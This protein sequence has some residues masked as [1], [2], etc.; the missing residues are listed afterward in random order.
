MSNQPGP[1]RR[2][3]SHQTGFTLVEIMIVVA[4]I[5][6]LAAIAVPAYNDYIVRSRITHATSGLADR[7]TRMEQFF[8]DNHVFFQAAAGS[9]PELNSP[10]CV[11]DATASPFFTFTCVA[12]ANTYTLT[13]T[14]RGPMT[15]FVY[16]INQAGVRTSALA[17]SISGWSSNSTTCWITNKGGA[18]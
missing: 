12:A 6:I 2:F 15:G 10:V 4:I 7:S 3:E 16:T 11:T 18:C 13:A 5:G 8:Q 1:T 9:N 17:T 14:G